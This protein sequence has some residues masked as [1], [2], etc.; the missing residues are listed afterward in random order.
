MV[1][2][3]FLRENMP[4]VSSI[5]RNQSKLVQ[6]ERTNYPRSFLDLKCL[7]SMSTPP[8]EWSHSASDFFEMFRVRNTIGCS[9]N[10]IFFPLGMWIRRLHHMIDLVL[11]HCTWAREINIGKHATTTKQ[12]AGIDGVREL[13]HEAVRRGRFADRM[14]RPRL[15]SRDTGHV[16]NISM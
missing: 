14:L 6:K 5:K 15:V 16:S 10:C 9:K 4:P 3:S 8:F 12:H 7:S 2:V 11:I 13:Q 1:C